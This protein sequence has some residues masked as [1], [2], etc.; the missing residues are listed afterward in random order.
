M[1][2]KLTSGMCFHDW[3]KARKDLEA[4]GN[5]GDKRVYKLLKTMADPQSDLRA[6]VKSRNEFLRRI[7]QSHVNLLGTMSVVADYAAWM[8]INQ[9]SIPCLISRLQK[10][11]GPYA[12]R[13]AAVSSRYLAFIAKE[14]APMYKAHIDQ[15]VIVIND[16]KNDKLIELGLQA[17]AAVSKSNPGSGP[18]DKRTIER[19]MKLALTGTPRQAKF[20]S[21]FISLCSD[22][23]AP[24]RLVDSL[25]E[26]LQSGDSETLLPS[27]AS[28][29]ELAI[30]ASVAFQRHGEDIVRHILDVVMA[31][32]SEDVTEDEVWV[33]E[34]QLPVVDRAKLYG[35]KTLTH[36]ALPWCKLP[37]AVELVE[38]VLEL[39]N[40]LLKN[41]GRVNDETN[42]G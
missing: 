2:K 12:E 38:P 23:T 16:K 3:D 33:D 30:S 4:F 37:N 40:D 28:L 7:E 15:L 26:Q 6:I 27:L 5:S 39:L 14:C 32:V 41:E 17:L 42:E 1:L 25:W 10:P 18:K 19:A 8:L 29:A 36:N 24:Q 9:S 21:R 31:G 35:I 20:A 34:D 22:N 13:I 11:E